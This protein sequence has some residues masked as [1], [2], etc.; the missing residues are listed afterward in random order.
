MMNNLDMEGED[1]EFM[2]DVS[3]KSVVVDLPEEEEEAQKAE[4]R[5]F[6][7]FFAKK[8]TMYEDTGEGEEEDL[9]ED[10][11]NAELIRKLGSHATVSDNEEAEL[12]DNQKPLPRP[13][14]ILKGVRG[15]AGSKRPGFEPRGRKELEELLQNEAKERERQRR[16]HVEDDLLYVGDVRVPYHLEKWVLDPEGDHKRRY[17][18][19]R[20]KE[21]RLKLVRDAYSV[22]FVCAD[23]GEK[24]S[25]TRRTACIISARSSLDSSAIPS[26]L[27]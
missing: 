17:R 8:E 9:A 24:N 25:G 3:V 2:S 11:R 20:L 6:Q 23:E 15:N 22:W 14:V 18:Q 1:T 26:T 19:Q 7:G 10:D 5:F 12:R 4:D 13:N 27:S 21:E 16:V